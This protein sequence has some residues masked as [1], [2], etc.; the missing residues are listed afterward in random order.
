MEVRKSTLALTYFVF[1]KSSA[2][3]NKRTCWNS[4]Q[5]ASAH[6]QGSDSLYLR[7][8]RQSSN[9]NAETV[10]A[11]VR[12]LWALLQTPAPRKV[13]KHFRFY[14]GRPRRL[15]ILGL[16]VLQRIHHN[17]TS[18]MFS[19]NLQGLC[20]VRLVVPARPTGMKITGDHR[21]TPKPTP[22][23]VP[24]PPRKVITAVRRIY[25]LF[26]QVP[27]NSLDGMHLQL[28]S[29]PLTEYRCVTEVLIL[30]R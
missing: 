1:G 26:V 14:P 15:A 6:C 27:Y 22:W 4:L 25:H 19:V 29:R 20:R 16:I 10:R 5:A 9:P 3:P 11:L 18:R 23:Q 7:T 8:C 13:H 21:Y 30:P 17:Q 28:R 12:P 2:V 24:I